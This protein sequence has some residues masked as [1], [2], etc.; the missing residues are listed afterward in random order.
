MVPHLKAQGSG[1][2]FNVS[3]ICDVHGSPEVGG[4]TASKYGL[5]G[6]SDCRHRES[7]PLGV[8]VT[9]ICPNWVNTAMVQEAPIT[10]KEMI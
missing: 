10:L 4:Y 3:S 7:A 6:L 1:Y 5:S 9:F 8:S 2:I